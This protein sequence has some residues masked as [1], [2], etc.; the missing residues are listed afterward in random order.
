[1]IRKAMMIQL[2]K[3]PRRYQHRG[4]SGT[5]NTASIEKEIAEN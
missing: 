2:N 1:M 5:T 4:T 3:K